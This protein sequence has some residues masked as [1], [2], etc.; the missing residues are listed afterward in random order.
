MEYFLLGCLPHPATF[1]KRTLFDA[2]PYD[3]RYKIAGDWEFLMYHLI[4]RNASYQHIDVTVTLFD[5][6][7]ISCTTNKDAHDV[8]LRKEATSQIIPERVIEDYDKFMGKRDDYNRLFYTLAHT[9][10]KKIFYCLTLLAIKIATINKGWCK[11]F[12]LKYF[13]TNNK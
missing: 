7:G 9:R 4:A 2:H 3:E 1:V 6:T 12:Y 10:Y 8:Q 5:T 13:S 11:S